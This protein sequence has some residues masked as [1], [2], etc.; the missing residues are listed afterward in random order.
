MKTVDDAYTEAM[1]AIDRIKTK[2]EIKMI[3]GS[4]EVNEKLLGDRWRW[5][6]NYYM[7]AYEETP[8]YSASLV[9]LLEGGYVKQH[10]HDN[11]HEVIEVLDGVIEYEV[12]ADNQGLALLKTGELR[13]GKTLEIMKNNA[14]YVFTPAEHMALMKIKFYK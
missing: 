1:E 9:R 7:C 13:K 3:Y 8:E 5:V 4:R 2:L 11:L 12:Y 10:Y 6:E 14:H